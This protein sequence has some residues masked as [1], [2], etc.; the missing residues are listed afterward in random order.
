MAQQGDREL[1]VSGRGQ[2][3]PGLK[4]GL[5]PEVRGGCKG[6]G[7]GG[8]RQAGGGAAGSRGP[9]F[10]KSRACPDSHLAICRRLSFV[11]EGGPGSPGGFFEISAISKERRGAGGWCGSRVC[12]V[13]A[14]GV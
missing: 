12:V 2:E 8:W 10:Q 3:R 7:V 4:S 13:W 9:N 6:E 1:E 11:R 5:G 14:A